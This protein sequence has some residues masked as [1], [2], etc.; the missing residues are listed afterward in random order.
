VVSAVFI[1]LI[2]TTDMQFSSLYRYSWGFYPKSG[3][4][5]LPFILFFFSAML[6][7]LRSFVAGYRNAL[8]GSVQLLRARTLLVGFAVG[9]LASLDFSA[10]FGL[11]W[12]PL[13]YIPIALFAGIA[14]YALV[15]Y[16]FMGIT[17]AF[18][19]RQ[20]VD[21]MNDALIVLDPDGVV[22]LVNQATCGLLGYSE[23]DLVGKKLTGS[24]TNNRA[25]AEQLEAIIRSGTVRK[26]EVDYERQENRHYSVNVSTSIMRNAIGEPLAT[27][28]VVSDVT[29]HKEADKVRET[30]IARLQETNQKL[31]ALDRMK[32]E[33]VNVVSHELRTPL[34]TIKAFAELI[35]MKPNMPDQQREKLVR[36]INAETDRLKRL[37]SDLLDLARI[38]AGSLRWRLEDVSMADVIQNAVTNMGPLFENKGLRLTSA[39]SPTLSVL[40]GDRDRLIQVVTNIL[41][42]AVKFTQGGGRVHV[43]VREE[44]APREQIVVDISDTGMGI[45]AED[46]DLIF[47]RFHRATDQLNGAIEGTGL[48]LAI[49][50]QI[51]EYHGGRIWAASTVGKG[52]TFT[53]TLPLAGKEA[54]AVPYQQ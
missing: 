26:Q 15:H 51:V 11:P 4:T 3:M 20:I 12:Y 33:F 1:T 9:Y 27:V 54:P 48:G 2:I 37:T 18:A 21:T 10:S 34:T 14:A 52:S 53:F 17:P 50:R 42:N 43:A 8:H 19:A 47:E 16:R 28:C 5:S 40:S 23:K 25:F 22:R 46:L 36:T 30:L 41:A 44:S 13:G 49:A 24:M 29:D 45:P 32:S 7:A 6:F 35:M 31:L 38:E 39:I